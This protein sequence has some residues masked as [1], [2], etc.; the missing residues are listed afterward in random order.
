MTLEAEHRTGSIVHKSG[1]VLLFRV[2]YKAGE[3]YIA[4]GP[5]QQK[6]GVI[7]WYTFRIKVNAITLTFEGDKQIG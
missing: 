5:F 4:R 2:L 3:R 7:L 1:L 6:S